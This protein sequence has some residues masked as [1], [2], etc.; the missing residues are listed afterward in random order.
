MRRFIYVSIIVPACIRTVFSAVLDF[1]VSVP[2]DGY[3]TLVVDSSDTR[4]VRNLLVET[5]ITAGDHRIR[6]NEKDHPW[7]WK[8]AWCLTR[9][10][11]NGRVFGVS[12]DNVW[13][14]IGRSGTKLVRTEGGKERGIAAFGDMLIVSYENKDK[15][16]AINLLENKLLTSV[17]PKSPVFARIDEANRRFQPKTG[18]STGSASVL[19]TF[20]TSTN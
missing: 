5:P 20:R 6:W 1:E 9:E 14:L 11:I 15:L 4:R 10:P 8:A 2:D 3:L 16:A 7:G 19:G 12:G 18:A 17:R 13:E